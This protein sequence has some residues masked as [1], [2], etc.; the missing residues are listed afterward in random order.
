MSYKQYIDQ[1]K[2]EGVSIIP[3]F[4]T[5]DEINSIQGEVARL[6]DN[7]D[8]SAHRS[9]FFTGE[10]QSSDKYFLDS[11]DKIRFVL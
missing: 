10:H 2:S 7:F 6:I 5:N 4:L 3:D 9:V 11:V 1:L 8:Y